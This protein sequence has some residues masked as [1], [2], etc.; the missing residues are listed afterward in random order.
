M[1]RKFKLYR[2]YDQMDCGP[3]CVRM[4]TKYYGKNYSLDSLRELC[5]IATDG[6]SLLG[7]DDALKSLGFSTIGCNVSIDQLEE[8]VPLPCILHW[9]QNHF[10]V[11]YKIKKDTFSNTSKFYIADPGA[12]Y[13][14]FKKNDFLKYWGEKANDTL[15][16][17]TV[18]LATPSENFESI[19][20]E[21]SFSMS[22][23]YILLYLKK[24]KK[25]FLQ[26]FFGILLTSF[27]QILLPLLT[28]SIVDVGI[29]NHDIDFIYLILIAQMG[30]IISRMFGDFIQKWILLHISTRINISLVSDFFIKLMKLPMSFFDTKLIGDILQRISDHDRVEQFLSFHIQNIVYSFFTF[31]AFGSVLAVYS[32]KIFSIFLAGSFLYTLWIFFFL[33][34]RRELDYKMFEQKALS[35]SKTYQLIS[36]IQEIKLQN[37][38][39]QK[40]W[41][42]EDLQTD[43]F[44]TNISFLKL[45]QI[46]TSGNVLIDESKNILITI[47][48]ATSV[49]NGEITLGMMLAI[50]YII[51]Q[52]KAPIDQVIS[53]IYDFQNTQISL[54]RINDIHLKKNEN[55]SNDQEDRSIK[56]DNDNLILNNLS[57]K[58]NKYSSFAL[59]DISLFI[60][61]GKVTAIVGASGSGKTTLIKL[62]LQ[63]Y[64]VSS[65]EI[66]VG[67][68]NLSNFK[69]DIWRNQCGAVMQ[70]GFI[71]SDS[72]ANNIIVGSEFD[73]ER[74][75]YSSK[76]A[77]IDIFVDSLPLK[78]DTVIGEEG[79]ELSRGQK[80]RILIARAIYKNPNFLFLDEATNSLDANNEKQITENLESFYQGKTVI[81]IAHRLSTVKYADQIVV[82]EKGKVKEIGNHESLTMV[83]G[84]YYHLVKNQ[85]ELG[86]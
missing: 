45:E 13:K 56:I 77:C 22:L 62:L 11:L 58:Y 74:L 26:L 86:D 82:L 61:K 32:L 71:F 78:Y 40:R 55:R 10:V 28:Q 3:A 18:L 59:E 36:G 83:R 48:A 19:E 25:Y 65:G 64:E 1:L 23:K 73:A 81:V 17:G 27:I 60:P 44:K 9:E 20:E 35:Q 38:E 47:I 76:M 2:Q 68:T 51:G 16:S 33:R 31:I 15:H 7:I 4:L 5:S 52:L 42:W 84:A 34:K 50:Q 66:K 37:Y 69:T 46:Q 41:E 14:S 49:V 57:F 54:E 75:L 21:G 63:Y 29:K 8:D 80:Q 30:L 43:L 39:K 79:Q 6:V 72:I 85:L 70:E 24:Y 53:F 12:G 67:N